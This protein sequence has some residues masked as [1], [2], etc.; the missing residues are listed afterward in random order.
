MNILWSILSPFRDLFMFIDGIAYSLLDNAYNIVIELSTGEIMGQEAIKSITNNLYILIGVIA[1]FR[2]A[3]VLVNS[4]IDPEKLNEKGKGLSNI[5]FRV[6]GMIILLIV[7]PFLFSLSYEIQ[8]AIVGADTGKNIIF[9]TLLGD[10]ASIT[11]KDNN[12]GKALQNIAL[13]SLIT[14]DSRYLQGTKD[15]GGKLKVCKLKK[16][17]DKKLTTEFE[18]SDCGFLPLTCVPT[19]NNE[20]ELRGGYI[21]DT[22][23]CKSSNCREA[24]TLYN[25]MYVAEDMS[26]SALANYAGVS[27]NLD[28]YNNEEVYVY[29][30]MLIVTTFVGGFMTYI[31]LS[32][33][34]DIAVRMFELVVLQIL[35][36]LFIATFV[37]PKSSQSGP[38]KNWLSAIGKSYASLYIKLAIIALMILLISFVNQA[39][40]FQNMGEISG[41]AKI[42]AVIGLLIFAKKAP[43]WIMDMIGIK[44]EDGLGG[45]SIGKKL[46]GM[47]LAGGL[48]KKAGEG[49]KKQGKKTLDNT[50]KRIGNKADRLLASAGARKQAKKNYQPDDKKGAYSNWKAKRAEARKVSDAVN[51]QMKR[52]FY[53]ANDF[54]PFAAARDKY[55]AGMQAVDPNKQTGR[56]AKLN[57]LSATATDLQ[58]KA[59]IDAVTMGKKI[60]DANDI[61]KAKAMYGS[62]FELN[63]DGKLDKFAFPLNTG[64][65]NAAY[66][67]YIGHNPVTEDEIRIASYIKRHNDHVT[68]DSDKISY[69]DSIKFNE[70]RISTLKINGQDMTREQVI[71]A[72]AATENPYT[73]SIRR[74]MAWENMMAQGNNYTETLKLKADATRKVLDLMSA[75]DQ[76]KVPNIPEVPVLPVEPV[77]NENGWE[78]DAAFSNRQDEY[79]QQM[80]EYN[81]QKIAYD[82]IAKEYSAMGTTPEEAMKK[83]QEDYAAYEKAIQS[84]RQTEAIYTSEVNKSEKAHYDALFASAT[85]ESGVIVSDIS[86]D[87]TYT[88]DIADGKKIEDFDKHAVNLNG[89]IVSKYGIYERD[90]EYEKDGKKR[91]VYKFV[92]RDMDDYYESINS[93]QSGDKTNIYDKAVEGTKPAEI[94]EAEKKES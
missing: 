71:S 12:G 44:G 26:P 55:A 66:K 40:I 84:A 36:P 61:K 73:T 8:G 21:Y 35:S 17:K 3:L 49:L 20:C 92:K 5:F 83:Y 67:D 76:L 94:K 31:I 37:D 45:L 75:R 4:I 48:V 29:N 57:K 60:K 72:E 46:G 65:M 7:T 53:A 22:D 33:A 81:E 2:L 64:Q 88:I 86:L 43:K 24:V 30:Y 91:N 18:E 80:Q 19:G 82:T 27:R 89:D 52:D 56:E 62:A 13:S 77:R 93:K 69:E 50:K 68:N 6:V 70:G 25:T 15:N 39:E 10:N 9:S 87:G 42:I 85:D 11:D 59:K 58:G 78:S 74:Q 38:F 41:W 28:E 47:A 51:A 79:V 23:I 1:F 32:F 63:S 34:I 54:R 14:V 16:D 90:S